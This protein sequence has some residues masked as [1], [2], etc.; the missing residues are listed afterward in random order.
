MTVVNKGQMG[1]IHKGVTPPTNTKITWLDENFLPDSIIFKKYNPVSGQWEIPTNEAR[2]PNIAARDALKPEIADATNVFVTDASADP[3]INAGWG[4]YKFNLATDDFTLLMTQGLIGNFHEQNTDQ[5]LDFGG[6]NQVSAVNADKWINNI[7]DD[8]GQ[9]DLFLANDG[10]Q[11]TPPFDWDKAE[12]LT[13]ANDGKSNGTY[14]ILVGAANSPDD[15]MSWM[16]EMH[17][18]GTNPGNSGMQIAH[19]FNSTISNSTPFYAF[20]FY[21]AGADTFGAWFLGITKEQLNNKYDKTGGL[22]SGAVSITGGGLT[23]N[24]A[25]QGITNGNITYKT[26]RIDIGPW[27]MLNNGA[28]IIPH[29]FGSAI[30]EANIKIMIISDDGTAYAPLITM[31]INGAQGGGFGTTNANIVLVRVN[32]GIY[33]SAAWSNLGV[34]RGYIWVTYP[35]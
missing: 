3:Q 12:L 26:S 17:R 32:G 4:Y 29:P 1:A 24:D 2:V 9:G 11:K 14:A 35:V 19:I 13:D 22:I 27:D 15:T 20:R 25:N 28:I 10:T 18:T 30:L 33:E 5:F 16:I 8:T 7:L 23:L 34:N 31:A 21:N 6:A